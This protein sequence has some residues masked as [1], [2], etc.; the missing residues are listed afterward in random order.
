MEALG[1]SPEGRVGFVLTPDDPYTVAD[2]DGCRDPETGDLQAWALE[3]VEA[4]DS[5]TEVS[6]SGRGLHV[7]LRGELPG[8]R[9]RS[10][11]VEL[12]DR[13]RYVTVTGQALPG[14]ER[15]EIAERG[16]QLAALYRR[17]FGEPEASAPPAEYSAPNSLPDG[18]AGDGELLGRAM[19]V[20]WF[21]AVWGGDDSHYG[22]DPSK[23]DY[24]V[25]RALALYGR[26]PAQIERVARSSPRAAR[27][28][29]ERADYWPR[30]VEAALRHTPP[31]RPGAPPHCAY[32]GWG[33]LGVSRGCS[34]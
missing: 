18:S 26:D 5:Y 15:G 12:Y 32:P 2:L 20:A 34:G 16:P 13:A 3:V 7:W 22:G 1:A 25:C 29:S 23:G 24:W 28:K 4:L 31:R 11:G 17:L 30:T 19:R 33:V 9:R 21:P 6:P 27:A 8:Q 14:Y 10:G